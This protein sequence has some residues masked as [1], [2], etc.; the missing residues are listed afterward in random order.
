MFERKFIINT[1]LPEAVR[2]FVW[3]LFSMMSDLRD[4]RIS[5]LYCHSCPASAVLCSNR[6]RRVASTAALS[7]GHE[8]IFAFNQKV[9][10][11]C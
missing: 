1:E 5:A 2:G 6:K 4:M 11:V 9:S 10:S 7:S 3:R 8:F